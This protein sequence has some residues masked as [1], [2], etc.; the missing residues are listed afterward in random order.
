MHR[1][2]QREQHGRCKQPVPCYQATPPGKVKPRQQERVD[3]QAEGKRRDRLLERS[4]RVVAPNDVVD[5]VKKPRIVT[6]AAAT[7]N[8]VRNLA[9]TSCTLASV[10]M[11]PLPYRETLSDRRYLQCIGQTH[12]LDEEEHTQTRSGHQVT[13]V[14]LLRLPAAPARRATPSRAA[15][16][17][18]APLC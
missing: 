12:L 2:D 16:P 3:E 14:T 9:C 1:G 17:S 13:P 7:S 10:F 15:V 4:P 11:I 8:Q 6:L 18:L 5:V